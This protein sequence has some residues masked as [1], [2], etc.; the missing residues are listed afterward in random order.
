MCKNRNIKA[1]QYKE[2]MFATHKGIITKPAVSLDCHTREKKGERD[3]FKAIENLREQKAF[4]LIELLIVVA[5]IGI[6]AAIA[7]PA[8]LGA[9]EKARKS[10]IVKANESAQSDLQHWL[11]SS[12]KGAVPTSPDA[13][14]VEVDTNWD[15]TV[16]VND[17]DLNNNGLFNI[18]ANAADSVMTQYIAGRT[19]G[20]GMNGQE[21]SPWAGM[22]TLI[23]ATVLFEDSGVITD[24]TATPIVVPAGGEGQVIFND[25]TA[26]TIQVLAV[27]N[28][29]GGSDT[30]NAAVLKCKVVSSE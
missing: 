19:G 2:V 5:I 18:G 13:A 10:N 7:I 26:T 21:I 6:L 27:D 4:T 22:G 24:C 3:M 1:Y 9:Q 16:N 11:N 28:G 12:I 23:P 14:L 8:Y 29:P 30:G 20:T 15:G 17:G 25:N